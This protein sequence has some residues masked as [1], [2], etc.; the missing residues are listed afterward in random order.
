MGRG[1][2][3]LVAAVA[4]LLVWGVVYVGAQHAAQP[5]TEAGDSGRASSAGVPSASPSAS[6]ID[7]SNYSPA[8][9]APQVRT[10][11][12]EAGIDPQLLMAILYNEDY[13]PHDPAFERAWLQANPDAALGI[14]NMHR[15]TFDQTKQGRPF[16]DRQWTDLL[17]NP[18]LAIESAAWYLH[19]LGADLPGR[20]AAPLTRDDLMALGYNTGP[21][22]MLA[23]ARGVPLGPSA[24]S[25][26]DRLRFNWSTAGAAVRG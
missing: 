17:G 18:A 13:K 23:F 14:A 26:L 7:W 1:R 24:Q 3:W 15:A 20:I 6:S 21:G 19:D 16:A 8:T 12:H 4:A 25:Y 22:N 2:W 5:R 11:A 9:F 10:S